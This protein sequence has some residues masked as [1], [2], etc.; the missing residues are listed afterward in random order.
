MP[1]TCPPIQNN[2]LY[3]V[4]VSVSGAADDPQLS[5][6]PETVSVGKSNALIVFELQTA[7]WQFPT[8]GTAVVI[9]GTDPVSKGNASKQFPV[10]WVTPSVLAIQD[11]N[12]CSTQQQCSYSCNVSVVHTASGLRLTKDPQ[13]DNNGER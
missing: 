9:A 13:I 3:Y 5:Y 7:G 10:A 12:N 2:N 6:S 11:I 1:N 8:D 4:E